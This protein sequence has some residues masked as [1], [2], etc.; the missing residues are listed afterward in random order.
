M[1]EFDDFLELP[2]DPDLGFVY[3]EKKLR[4]E[5]FDKLD[6]ESSGTYIRN[7]KV[8]YYQKLMAFHDAYEL[9]FLNKISFKRDEEEFSS[10]FDEFIHEID[11]WTTQIQIRHAQRLRPIS[12]V[13]N[14]T[15]EIRKQ[16]HSY[17]SKIRE[18]VSPMDLPLNK[19]ENI[20]KKIERFG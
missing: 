7:R 17:I 10:Q 5:M 19:K 2:E 13:L 6:Y 8:S 18:T 1:P 14:L 12:T 9:S 4:S 11:Y 15:P 3:F 20:L 16:L